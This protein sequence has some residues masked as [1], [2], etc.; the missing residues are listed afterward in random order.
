LS[1]RAAWQHF[2]LG[3]ALGVLLGLGLAFG[4]AAAFEREPAA[5]A[6]EREPAAARRV[7]PL[8]HAVV[9]AP[10]PAVVVEPAVTEQVGPQLSPEPKS[11]G[12]A[13]KKKRRTL[14]R[15]KRGQGKAFKK[16]M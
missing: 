11:A 16:T 7:A 10:A 15:S 14:G 3:A 12:G 13:M 8:P 5:A 9:V 1:E 2:A 6:F 4:A